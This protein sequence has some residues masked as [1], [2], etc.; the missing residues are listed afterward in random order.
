MSNYGEFFTKMMAPFFEG[1]LSIVKS[2]F[3]GLFQM[4]N[5]LNYIEV[6]QNY[7]QELHGVGLVILIFSI[8]FLIA[9]FA[10][11][12]FLIVRAIRV[13][14]RYRRNVRL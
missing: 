2:F 4:F 5:I 3:E 8:I 7:K 13:Y 11:I 9:I 10:L 12:V 1:L 6:I 14:L